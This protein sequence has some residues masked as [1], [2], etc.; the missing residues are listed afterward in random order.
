MCELEIERFFLSILESLQSNKIEKADAVR[1]LS[2]NHEL[3]TQVLESDVDLSISDCYWM[4]AH[5]TEETIFDAEIQY[6]IDCYRNKRKYNLQEK[7]MFVEE[8]KNGWI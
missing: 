4:I 7:L 5:L 2:D 1:I 8:K 6:F 3:T